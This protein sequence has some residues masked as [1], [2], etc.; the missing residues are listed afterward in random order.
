MQTARARDRALRDRIR[1]GDERAF[2]AFAREQHAVLVR[3]AAARLGAR[4][5][6]IDEC[7][8]EAWVVFLESLDRFE[9]R[10][11]LRTFL[12][13]ILLNVVRNRLRAEARSMPLSA[14]ETPLADDNAPTVAGSR[15]APGTH[16]WP[17]HWVEPPRR[18]SSDPACAREMR[19]ALEHAIGQLPDV[20]RE[21]LV[22]RDVLGWD[23]EE[24]CNALGV[25]DTHQRVLLHRARARLRDTLE[26]RF[27]E[28]L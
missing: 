14:L 24:T 21:V 13:G 3:I 23:A 27:G 22:M 15:F 4:S 7:A 20:Q 19:E 17:G 28:A 25:T 1:A 8:Q 26:T 18:W 11:S 6:I 16:A 2:T 9:G 12:V 10:S 5:P